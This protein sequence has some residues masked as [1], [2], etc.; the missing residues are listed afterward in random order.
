VIV[1]ITALLSSYLSTLNLGRMLDTI[2]PEVIGLIA[3]HISIDTLQ[4]PTSILQSSKQLNDTLSPRSNPNL[5]ARIFKDSFDTSAADRRCT[6][7]LTAKKLTDEL[8]L[9]TRALGRLKRR[10]KDGKVG[11]VEERDLWVIYILLIEHGTSLPSW[12]YL[13]SKNLMIR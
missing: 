13:R 10:V 2:P 6:S 8:E 9:R 3:Y 4:P 12:F 5:Y 11:G 1:T 7:P